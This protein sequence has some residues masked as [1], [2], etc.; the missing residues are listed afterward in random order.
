MTTPTEKLVAEGVSIWLDD[1]SRERISSGNLA[2]L[3]VDRNVTGV[4]TNPT[5]FAAALSKG[6]R[7]QEQVAELAGQGVDVAEAIFQITTEDVRRACDLLRP[8]YDSTD[9]VDGRVSIEVDPGLARDTDGTVEMALG[10]CGRRST[11]RTCTS[12]SRPP[13]RVC[14]RSA[15]FSPKA[16]R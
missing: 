3:I 14:R 4:T 7:Y 6:D 10:G 8:V 11:G 9:G 1:L 5:I 16:S 12:R 13:S 2:A 15:P